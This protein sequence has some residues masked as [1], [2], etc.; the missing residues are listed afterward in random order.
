MR[1]YIFA[2]N[3]PA[4]RAFMRFHCCCNIRN[5]QWLKVQFSQQI[6]D[7]LWW[8]LI[9]TVLL[10]GLL[11][12]LAYLKLR[13][14]N[15]ALQQANQ[16]LERRSQH[17]PLTGLYNRQY[18]DQQLQQ[19]LALCQRQQLPMTLAMI[20]LDHFKQVNDECG[21]LFG[22]QC[23]K[24]FA[25]LLQASFQR[26]QDILVRYG[27]EEFILISI[28]TPQAS[29]QKLLQAFIGQ[30]A[31]TPVLWE[32][33]SRCCTISIGAFCQ[34]PAAGL[35]ARQLLQ[36][37]DTALYQAKHQGRDQLVLVALATG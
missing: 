1:G 11:G 30:I 22:D 16:E 4:Y 28:G 21:H 31:A 19:A 12:A 26:P 23:L 36:L 25:S 14:L 24:Q 32:Q 3:N 8:Q 20:D 37:A 27:G 17:D 13:A 35:T 34:V 15:L 18:F 5:N 6:D 10:L 33:Q 9:I 29:M 7:K 2:V